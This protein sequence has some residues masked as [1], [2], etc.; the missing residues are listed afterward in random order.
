[1]ATHRTKYARS[2]FEKSMQQANWLP[3]GEASQFPTS[4]GAY[5]SRRSLLDAVSKDFLCDRVGLT[6]VA[7]NE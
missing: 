6:L 4:R 2:T 7:E 3:P 5:L 1:M